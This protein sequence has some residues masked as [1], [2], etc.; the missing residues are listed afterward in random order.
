[1]EVYTRIHEALKEVG[2]SDWRLDVPQ[3]EDKLY[4]LTTEFLL[5]IVSCSQLIKKKKI[6]EACEQ[7]KPI[8][9]KTDSKTYKSA[10][11]ML[12]DCYLR[13]K[14][15]H[16]CAKELLAAAP[17]KTWQDSSHYL[18]RSYY[19]LHL[20]NAEDALAFANQALELNRD[21][22]PAKVN[23][24]I[25]LHML[26]Q[27]R[28]LA[29]LLKDLKSPSATDHHK[30]AAYAIEGKLEESMNSLERAIVLGRYSVDDACRDVA[31][32]VFWGLEPFE[33][34]L[35]PFSKHKPFIYPRDP[36]PMSKAERIV[37]AKVS[38]HSKK[39]SPT[40]GPKQR[41]KAAT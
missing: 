26:G 22:A 35:R 31:F 39:S 1:M 10:W 16:D 14:S 17:I 19:S 30:A 32:R 13:D 2:L 24:A 3:I 18:Q 33:R 28:E 25:S 34:H 4:E 5:P 29:P 40:S 6:K 36:C 8:V 23:K 11:T 41:R 27:R 7:L 21:L 38:A 20:C 15:L 12:M 37:R 9:A